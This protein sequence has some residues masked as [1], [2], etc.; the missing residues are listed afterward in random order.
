MAPKKECL[1]NL[2]SGFSGSEKN[3]TV[4]QYSE[5]T[6]TNLERWGQSRSRCPC[7][8]GSRSLKISLLLAIS[9]YGVSSTH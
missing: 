6:E 5:E 1:L 8:Y 4:F 3:G 7:F 2:W 9:T